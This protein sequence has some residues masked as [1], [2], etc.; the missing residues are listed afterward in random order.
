MQQED[1]AIPRLEG[2]VAT[3]LTCLTVQEQIEA[4]N[5]T[6]PGETTPRTTDPA[7]EPPVS[8]LNPPTG[9]VPNSST[10]QSE[11]E[12]AVVIPPITL[13]SIFDTVHAALNAVLLLLPLLAVAGPEAFAA[14]SSGLLNLAQILRAA[15]AS[16]RTPVQRAVVTL[17]K[18]KLAAALAHAEFRTYNID[19]PT[20]ADALDRAFGPDAEAASIERAAFAFAEAVVAFNAA[21]PARQSP[22]AAPSSDEPQPD[23][24]AT[25]NLRWDFLTRALTALSTAN[26]EALRTQK[27]SSAAVVASSADASNQEWDDVGGPAPT[28]GAI[29]ERRGDCELLRAALREPPCRH[30][31]AVRQAARLASNAATYYGGARNLALQVPGETVEAADLRV[32]AAAAHAL[33]GDVRPVEE[34]A[35]DDP[36]RV[37]EVLAEMVDEGLLT[38]EWVR[39]LGGQSWIG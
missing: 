17:D 18:A 6:A 21:A 20:Y 19:L 27:V 30:E 11:E 33:A 39:S 1:A 38:A 25:A 15:D 9:A 3:F 10:T 24:R 16:A 5:E 12:W 37:K 32:K 2:A 22:N 29:N 8:R 36:E 34:A 35:G 28:R 14:S 7:G 31:P 26:T 13:D 4:M 23:A